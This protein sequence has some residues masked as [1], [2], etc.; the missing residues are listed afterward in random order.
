MWSEVVAP[1]ITENP[2]L[3][4]PLEDEGKALYM[5]ATAVVSSYSFMLGDDKY[6]VSHLWKPYPG[7]ASTALYT[8]ATVHRC[9]V[10]V[11]VRY[12][13]RSCRAKTDIR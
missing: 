13:T 1:F 3:G 12:R 5:W 9:G 4:L 11:L 7:P 6:Q 10:I 8:W 2:A